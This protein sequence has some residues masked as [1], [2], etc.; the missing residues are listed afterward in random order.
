MFESVHF[1]AVLKNHMTSP[2]PAPLQ[3]PHLLTTT[4]TS[5]PSFTRHSGICGPHRERAVMS[6]RDHATE[7]LHHHSE[8]GGLLKSNFLCPAAP[9]SCLY[10]T[11]P[12]ASVHLRPNVFTLS[13][14]TP[15]FFYN[16]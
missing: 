8:G 10:I 1:S 12:S 13:S 2:D 4:I 5:P 11:L 3:S 16:T 15:P 6:T 7:D 9:T 14:P